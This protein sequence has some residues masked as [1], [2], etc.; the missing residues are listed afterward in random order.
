MN[1]KQ[2]NFAML[3]NPA[4]LG[5]LEVE[6]E[7]LSLEVLVEVLELE[8][9]LFELELLDLGLVELEL[10]ELELLDLGLVELKLFKPEPVELVSSILEAVELLVELN[11]NLAPQLR[12]Y[13][14][15]LLFISPQLGQ[16]FSSE[17]LLN[18]LEPQL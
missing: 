15:S 5:E 13:L 10:F 6:L 4:S 2:Q 9:E 18:S 16:T 3:P 14:L 1:A 7:D 8:L 12:Q 17:I 11:S